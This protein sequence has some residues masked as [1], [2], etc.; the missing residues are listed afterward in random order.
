MRL[1]PGYG[2]NERNNAAAEATSA[3][4][5]RLVEYFGKAKSLTDIDHPAASRMVAWRRG[6][7]VKDRSDAPLISNGTVNRSAIKPLQRLFTFAKAEGAVFEREP[8]W[9]E[10]VL[11]EPAERVREP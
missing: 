11:P 7:H 3:N 5:A 4:L 1:L 10:L 6:H 9:S 8:K 2:T